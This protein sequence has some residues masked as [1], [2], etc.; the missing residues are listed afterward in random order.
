MTSMVTPL[1]AQIRRTVRQSVRRSFVTA[2]PVVPR[3]RAWVQWGQRGQWAAFL[4]QDVVQRFLAEIAAPTWLRSWFPQPTQT[5]IGT[6]T[7][8]PSGDPDKPAAKTRQLPVATLL[9]MMSEK[10]GQYLVH[11]TFNQAIGELRE[12]T[13]IDASYPAGTLD[14]NAPP[15][16]YVIPG[17]V[18][19]EYGDWCVI[20]EK[21]TG[22]HY[23]GSVAVT[24]G[25]EGAN[26]EEKV[27]IHDIPTS[28]AH[29]WCTVKDVKEA[30]KQYDAHKKVTGTSKQK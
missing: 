28:A 21:G 14:P 7:G 2:V 19:V 5:A 8:A 12:G 20:F 4:S 17:L 25:A 23:F 26:K 3:A 6:P 1:R 11:R 18:G 13:V 16:I 30:K 10:S 29:G 24:A 15:G 27:C 9:D 22:D